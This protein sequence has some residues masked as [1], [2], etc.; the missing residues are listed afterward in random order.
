MK[1]H[2]AQLNVARLRHPLD[3]P[4][5]AGFR[6]NLDLVNSA[7]K[8]MPGFVWALEDAGG[9]A[10]SFRIDDDPQMLVNLSVWESA[11]H[12]RRFVLG[13]VHGAFLKRRAEW[14]EPAPGRIDLVLWHVTAGERP[15]LA[16]AHERLL[17][18]RR[19]G[20]SEAAFGWRE[21]MAGE[22]A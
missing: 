17:K 12:L 16:D 8:R 22:N 5:S 13:P 7:A 3:D 15:T 18:L 21:A 9:T 10:T 11:A 6:D 1:Q 4:R 20:P 14:F 19:E 2:L